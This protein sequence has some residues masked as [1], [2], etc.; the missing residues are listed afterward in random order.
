M[1]DKPRTQWCQKKFYG[2]PKQK[3]LILHQGDMVLAEFK[4]DTRKRG[5]VRK[6]HPAFV[7]STDRSLLFDSRVWL[8]PMFRSE[9]YAN[10][11]G[12]DVEIS[13]ADCRELSTSGHLSIHLLQSV[14]KKQIIKKLGR[15]RNDDIHKEIL[16]KLFDQ[17][18]GTP[19][20]NELEG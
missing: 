5:F 15:V 9:S 13:Q 20:R 8:I 10:G 3:N 11:T 16:R 2:H 19:A 12:N 18:E 1:V 6:N 14:S 4:Y 7:V 17:I